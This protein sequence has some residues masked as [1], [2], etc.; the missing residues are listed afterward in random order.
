MPRI[1][2]IFASVRSINYKALMPFVCGGFPKPG[3]LGDVLRA[4]EEGGASIV[5]IGIPF[6]DPIADGPVIA[7]AMHDALQQG[8]TPRSIFDEVAAARD[9]V[10]VGIV[11][12]VSV[13]IVHRMGGPT[14]FAK[15]AKD[16][17]FDGLI[18]PDAPLEESTALRDAARVNALSLSLLIAP[19][20]PRERALQI[21]Q[22]STGFIYMLARAGITGDNA[23]TGDGPGGQSQQLPDIGRRVAAL[24]EVTNLP[25]AAGFGIATKEHVAAV[26]KYA[27]AAIVGSA[28]VRHMRQTAQAGKFVPHEVRSFVRN[29]A[30]GL[31]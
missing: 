15:Q 27:D 29:L 14:G 26:T 24:R 21:A 4:C 18:V 20:T 11:A 30:E 13:S 16:A 28:L 25:I 9:K 12:M 19:S 17:G 10:G 31:A 1:D 5:E 6:S 7:T 23:P 22:A 8:V 3:M 2:E